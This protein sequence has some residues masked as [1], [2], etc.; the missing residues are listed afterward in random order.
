MK[1][2]HLC[3]ALFVISGAPAIAAPSAPATAVGTPSKLELLKFDADANYFVT[4]EGGY[5][6]A[7]GAAWRPRLREVIKSESTT[8]NLAP[9]LG[10]E[11]SKDARD[12][13]LL[14]I[15][16]LGLEPE[17]EW[18]RFLVAVDLGA[19]LILQDQDSDASLLVGAQLAW[20]PEQTLIFP[21]IER[22]FLRYDLFPTST[23][24]HLITLGVGINLS[25]KQ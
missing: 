6:F 7:G 18:N 15:F 3:T 9:R 19:A 22:L 4:S 23:T 8:F 12:Q 5:A 21:F 25:R 24:G 1:F 2:T 16:V 11:F 13:G 20:K 10:V 14:P 17:A